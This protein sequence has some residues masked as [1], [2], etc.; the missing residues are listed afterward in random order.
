MRRGAIAAVLLTVLAAGC[1]GSDG[2]P[3]IA[4]SKTAVVR[5]ELIPDVH[6]F[7]EPVVA[8]VDVV[9]NR[10]K[11]DPDAVRLKARFEPYE[12]VGETREARTDIG[13][14][15]VIQYTT[16]LRCLDE[17]C[18]PRTADGETTVSQLPGLPP[19]LPGQQRDEKVKYEFPPATVVAEV[20][21]K[22][23]TLGRVAWAPLRSL[24][25]INWYDSSVVGQGFPFV[26]NVTQ[27]P[28][29]EYRISPTV[30][31]LT[32]LAVAL[33]LLAIPGFLVWDRR[34]R[35]A[36]PKT[37]APALSPLERALRLVEWASRRPS[38][39]ERREA[40][41]ALAFELAHEE[42]VDAAERARQHG[43]SPPEPQPD[44]MNELVSTIRE[45][46]GAAAS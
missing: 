4:A 26:A 32:L 36:V 24:S 35:H 2:R 16:T 21:P 37:H 6:L 23:L 44:E 45:D 9:V 17:R 28:E 46:T 20:E 31:G 7:G 14:Y 10:D 8:R 25:R 39:R 13:N 12:K 3:L 34:R 41:E 38:A 15:T 5:G 33:A 30:V 18:I 29:P 42:D 27:V 22:E 1:G 19:F 43:W 11:V 40:L